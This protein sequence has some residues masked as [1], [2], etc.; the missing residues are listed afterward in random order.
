LKFPCGRRALAGIILCLCLAAC[1]TTPRPTLEAPPAPADSHITVYVVRR[2]WHVD[3][4]LAAADLRPPLRTLAAAFPGA[5]YLLFGFGDERYL[6]HGGSGDLLLALWPGA[7]V[8]LITSLHTSAVSAAFDVGAVI[9]LDL[10]QPQSTALQ[11]YVWQSLQT[12]QG[13]ATSLAPGPYAGSMYYP[14]AL[15]YSA[16]RTCNTW[17]AAALRAAQLPVHSSG[18]IFAWQLWPQVERLQRHSV[19]GP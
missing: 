9:T 2:G 10:T 7:G 8:I 4:G 6:L 11:N 13:A 5:T 14:S 15:S 12:Q 19:T 17:A 3:V 18:V 16:A 1:S